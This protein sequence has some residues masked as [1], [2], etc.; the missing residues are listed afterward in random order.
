MKKPLVGREAQLAFIDRWLADRRHAIGPPALFV[1]GEAGVGKTA[2]LDA[3][4]TGRAAVRHGSATPW[5]AA[6]LALLG[7]L[8]PNDPVETPLALVL[9]DLQWSDDATLELLPAL[10]DAI[11]NEPVAIIGAY[12]G[13]EL[14]RGH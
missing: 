8:V 9:D 6:P 12:R 1:S 13:D 5:P 7:Q 10:I 11:A 14:P 4:D 3:A 2:L